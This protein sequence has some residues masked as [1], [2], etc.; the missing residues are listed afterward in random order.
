MEAAMEVSDKWIKLEEKK[1][2]AIVGHETKW[3]AEA[4]KIA[5][6]EEVKVNKPPK[7]KKGEAK[8]AA[9]RK[10]ERAELRLWRKKQRM[11]WSKEDIMR[12]MGV[13][14]LKVIDNLLREGEEMQA[15]GAT[16]R[17]NTAEPQPPPVPSDEEMIDPVL[18]SNPIPTPGPSTSTPSV[19]P[20]SPAI[21]ETLSPASRRRLQKRLYMRR[22]RAEAAGHTDILPVQGSTVVQRGKPGRK[23]KPRAK[24]KTEGDAVVDDD[25][26]DDEE[27]EEEDDPRQAHGKTR[28][29]KTKGLLESTNMN[30]EALHKNGLGLFHLSAL[31]KLMRSG[32]SSFYKCVIAC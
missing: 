13:A 24:R 21:P 20:E 4:A 8:G 2:A 22:K 18:R 6:D 5:R 23:S 19:E 3:E 9:E 26:E 30:A 16:S 27:E 14:H 1:A 12:S 17:Q 31:S 11:Q 10:R 28:H 15:V 25:Q 29:Y 32:R 7:A